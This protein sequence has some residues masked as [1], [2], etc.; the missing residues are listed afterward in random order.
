MST[1]ARL[2]NEAAHERFLADGDPELI[3]G[4]GTPAGRH[5]ARRRADLIARAGRLGPGRRVLEVGCGTGMFTE[6]WARSGADILAV[7][8]AP[9]LI[10]RARARRI[11]GQV[12]FAARP[13]EECDAEGFDATVGSSILHHLEIRQALRRIYELL[14]PSGRMAFAE[15]NMLNPQVRLTKNVPWIKR[16]MGDSP[17]ETAFFGLQMRYL[18]RKAGFRQV[19]VS[20]FDFLHPYTPSVLIDAVS[21]VGRVMERVP[22]VRSLAGSLIISGVRE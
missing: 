5:R 18:L 4:W 15:P 7:D 16:A 19:R 6:M 11:E 8:I 1:E 10:E 20:T 17:N 14:K 12:R 22:G 21:R 13:F 9:E 2:D 3:W